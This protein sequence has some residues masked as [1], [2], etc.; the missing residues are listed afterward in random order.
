MLASVCTWTQ[1]RA[2]DELSQL[3]RRK[4]VA[5]CTLA[6]TMQAKRVG[7]ACHEPGQLSPTWQ[8]V[9][10][11]RLMSMLNVLEDPWLLVQAM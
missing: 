7:F 9:G 11:C 6:A 5:C 8:M 4:R 2:C 1:G 10:Q 3:I